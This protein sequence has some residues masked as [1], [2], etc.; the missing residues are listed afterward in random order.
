[1]RIANDSP[2]GL[3][4]SA[5]TA[6]EQHGFLR[7][8]SAFRQ[9]WSFVNHPTKVEADCLWRYPPFRLRAR[10]LFWPRPQGVRNHKP[11]GTWSISRPIFRR[12]P[13]TAAAGAFGLHNAP[14]EKAH[15]TERKSHSGYGR[16]LSSA[17]ASR[18][19]WPLTAW[20]SRL[21]T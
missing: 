5:F 10:K 11:I 20:I 18:C 14:K 17:V 16:S 13:Y 2:F 19:G 4:G 12:H 9:G 7:S 21:S 15:G 1:M 8:R 6:D 3:G